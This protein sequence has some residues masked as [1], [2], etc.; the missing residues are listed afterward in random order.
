MLQGSHCAMAITQARLLP[1]L[2]GTRTKSPED[3]RNSFLSAARAH[4][5]NVRETSTHHLGL[6][7]HAVNPL[8]QHPSIFHV[9]CLM[10]AAPP[11]PCAFV[12]QLLFT[13]SAAIVALSSLWMCRFPM[14]RKTRSD[15]LGHDIFQL[16]YSVTGCKIDENDF[17][18][19]ICS[20]TEL[21]RFI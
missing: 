6:L 7:C 5:C 9:F 15:M 17:M 4:L 20:S 14:R 11:P 10:L 1:S 19:W 13:V 12:Q 8:C 3:P 16:I 21:H 18:G 2:S